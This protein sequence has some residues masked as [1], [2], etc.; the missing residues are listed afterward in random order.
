[1]EERHVHSCIY[2]E[3]YKFVKC[4]VST[5]KNHTTLTRSN[6]LAV[7]RIRPEGTKIISDA[8]LN[9]YKFAGQGL[10]VRF[11]QMKRKFA[12][13]RIV[14]MMVLKEYIEYIR[15]TYKSGGV[16]NTESM[17]K[18]ETMYPLKIRKLGFENWMWEH[19][20]DED[21]W[22]KFCDK[23]QVKT[24]NISIRIIL[25]MKIK[26]F[27]RLLHQFENPNGV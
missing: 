12:V 13:D 6:C 17:L 21:V 19:L 25:A 7:D 18:A 1:M 16:F 8:E 3:W 15:I 14:A 24:E 23:K 27:N 2:E 20:L 5:C 4:E 11:V 22:K 9:L 26:T 10:S